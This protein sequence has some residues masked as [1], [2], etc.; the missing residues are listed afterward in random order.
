MEWKEFIEKVRIILRRY[1]REYNFIYTDDSISYC[2]N[3]KEF[4]YNKLDY[5]KIMQKTMEFNLSKLTVSNENTYEVII[6]QTNRMI[7]SPFLYNFE[8]KLIINDNLN[9]IEYIF[10]EMS[11]IMVWNIIKEIDMDNFKSNFLVFPIRFYIEE[12]IELFDFLR[13]CF[14][15]LYSIDLHHDGFIDESK[16]YDYVNSFLFNLCYNYGLSFRIINSL[17]ELLNIRYRNKYNF[18]K[19]EEINPPK[20]LYKQ[21]LTEQYHMAVSSEDPFVQ[22]IG[23]YHIIEYFFEE[24]YKEG[25]VNDVKEILLDPGFSTKKNKD[26]MKLVDLVSKKRIDIKVG[27]EPEALELTL[28]KF[29][30]IEKIKDKLNDYDKELIEYYKNNKVEFS[31]GDIVDLSEDNRA[32]FKQL[33]KRIYKTRNSLVHN[34]S[35]E[36]RTN[37]RGTYNHFKDSKFLLKEIPL[38]KIISEEIILKSATEI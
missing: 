20:L 17:D 30:D 25:I 9:K 36:T 28:T 15:N 33:A 8:E 24:I 23:Y 12:K 27:N 1:E 19:S 38:L 14:R 32:V 5:D 3:G 10:Q 26:I 29:I 13:L 16:I 37:E 11:D 4:E 7:R 22:F 34:K 2:V 6:Y 31:R 35:N 18:Y 21:D